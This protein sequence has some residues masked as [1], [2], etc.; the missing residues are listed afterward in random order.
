MGAVNY[1]RDDSL[2]KLKRRG[3]KIQVTGL[4]ALQ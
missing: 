1:T 4:V 2:V 3:A